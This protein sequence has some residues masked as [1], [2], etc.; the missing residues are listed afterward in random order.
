M[1]TTTPP[2][3]SI[4][5]P[6]E[7][8]ISAIPRDRGSRRQKKGSISGLTVFVLAVAGALLIPIGRSG[9]PRTGDP[10][11]PRSSLLALFD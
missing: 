4:E 3:V 1:A 6:D 5:A 10:F 8:R 11:R 2:S 7:C 9:L